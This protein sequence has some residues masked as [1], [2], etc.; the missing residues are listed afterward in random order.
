MNGKI[1]S[2]AVVWRPWSWEQATHCTVGCR[3]R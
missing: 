3:F 1:Y 2:R